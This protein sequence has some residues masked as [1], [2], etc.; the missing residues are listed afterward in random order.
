MLPMFASQKQKSAPVF[1]AGMKLEAKDRLN[2]S[3][4]AVATVQDVREGKLLIHFDGWTSKFDYWCD[5]TTEDIHPVGWCLEQGKSLQP[6]KGED[7]W[8]QRLKGGRHAKIQKIFYLL[9]VLFGWCRAPPK[10]W[11]FFAVDSI[12]ILFFF[13]RFVLLFLYT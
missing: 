5:R 10:K 13:S 2:P 3:L 4:I 8:G 12:V 9:K 7:S 6:P 1:K 11:H